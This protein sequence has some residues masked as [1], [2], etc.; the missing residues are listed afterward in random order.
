MIKEDED[1]GLWVRSA[2]LAS[3]EY[4]VEISV[5]PERA[6]PLTREDAVKYAVAC[7]ARVA[8]AEH[9]AAVYDMFTARLE[10]PGIVA[11]Q[12][13]AHEVRPGRTVDH[14][15]TE[16]LKFH[17]SL[18]A[19]THEPFI[20]L[21]MDDEPTGALTTGDLADHAQA[22]LAVVAVVELDANLHR[23]LTEVVGVDDLRARAAVDS[24]SEHWP[25]REKPRSE[26]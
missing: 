9:D 11:A 1:S 19:A 10:L 7:F 17:V 25:T 2:V 22:V 26:Q 23:V 14:S 20:S 8:E 21:E 5:G 15:A 16:P 13:I 3:G 6:W 24:L 4:G 12:A 18:G